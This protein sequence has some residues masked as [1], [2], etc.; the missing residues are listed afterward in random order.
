VSVNSQGGNI[1]MKQ[2]DLQMSGRIDWLKELWKAIHV[3]GQAVDVTNDQLGNAP[4]GVSLKFQYTLL[5]LKVNNMIIEAETALKEHLTFLA[6]EI[7]KAEKKQYD[8]EKIRVTFNKSPITNDAEL[9][10][11]IIDSDNLVPESILLAAHPLIH[12]ADQAYKDL[13]EQRKER[14]E[15]QR[16]TFGTLQ[17]KEE[18]G[19]DA[20]KEE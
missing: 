2:L 10:Q 14:I 18:A 16:R 20:E 9:V 17:E 6:G 1:E 3:F 8:P 5:D 11:M 4:S 15:E 13:M 12:D 19:E 7:N